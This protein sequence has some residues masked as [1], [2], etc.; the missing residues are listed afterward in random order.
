[1]TEERRFSVL[2]ACGDLHGVA[3]GALEMAPADADTTAEELQRKVD[4]WNPSMWAGGSR[5]DDLVYKLAKQAL[6]EYAEF[7]GEVSHQAS[8]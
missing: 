5:Y 1:M 4:N 7:M 2:G 6:R 3:T 8:P